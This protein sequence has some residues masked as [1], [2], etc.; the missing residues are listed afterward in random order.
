[1]GIGSAIKEK[2]YLKKKPTKQKLAVELA[3]QLPVLA[4]LPEELQFPAP[5]MV[6]FNHL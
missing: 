6:A 1:M 3:H 5:T 4:A 2:A